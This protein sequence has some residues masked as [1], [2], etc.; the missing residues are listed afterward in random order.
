MSDPGM[1]M[2]ASA[3]SLRFRLVAG[4][5]VMVT[6]I[7]VG[8]TVFAWRA[9]VHEAEELFDAHLAQTAALLVALS[10]DEPEEI[11]EHLPEHRYVHRVAFQVWQGPVLLAHSQGAPETPLTTEAS[12]F[13]NSLGGEGG[14]RVYSLEDAQTG[15]R[16]Q[17]AESLRERGAISRELVWR[18]L[19]PLGIALPVLALALIVLIRR[20]LLPLS[21]LADSIGERSADCLDTIPMSGVLRETRPIIVQLNQLFARLAQSFDK[22]RQFTA[23]AAHELRTPLAAIRAHAQVALAEADAVQRNSALTRVIEGTDRTT[24]LVEQLLTL[25]RLD[26]T[27]LVA[28]FT[29]C[30]LRALAV[31]VVAQC[32][33]AAMAR[34]MD[35]EVE[36]GGPV[37][38]RGDAMLLSVLLRNLI[39]NAI[40]YAP[41]ATRVAVVLREVPPG[42][43]VMDQGP[44]IPTE[45]RERVVQRFVR[46]PGQDACGAGLGLSIVA[47][48]AELHGARLLIDDWSQGDDRPQGGLAVR[49]VF[50]S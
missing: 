42:L 50:P 40:R 3:P 6:V 9:A 15:Y 30:D 29:S 28:N 18:L 44:G 31:E 2:M 19:L 7:W 34:S 38:I 36:E 25:A 16:V 5:L 20:S 23:D 4:T 21:R 45:A 39:D 13:S 33:P 10:G 35:L 49:V 48:I 1:S 46:L 12:G 11:A 43:V 24:H 41:P 32:A 17:V 37:P 8:V 14:W 27:Q 26:S 47:R 22:E